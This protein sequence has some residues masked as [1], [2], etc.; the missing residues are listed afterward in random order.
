M[1]T[2]V[3]NALWLLQRAGKLQTES[4]QQCLSRAAAPQKHIEPN[5]HLQVKALALACHLDHPTATLLP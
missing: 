4:W 3:A 5:R 2:E 1:L